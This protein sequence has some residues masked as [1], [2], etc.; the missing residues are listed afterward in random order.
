MSFFWE[1]SHFNTNNIKFCIYFYDKRVNMW[2]LPHISELLQSFL[3]LPLSA[4][5]QSRLFEKQIF[6]LF[7]IN[8]SPFM[9]P[10]VHNRVHKMVRRCGRTCWPTKKSPTIPAQI[11]LLNFF[12]CLHSTLSNIIHKLNVSEHKLLWTFFFALVCGTRDQSL[13]APFG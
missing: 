8:S 11:L 1:T 10:G 5:P 6:L 9:E 13:S 2:I 7:S 12:W 4:S 3:L